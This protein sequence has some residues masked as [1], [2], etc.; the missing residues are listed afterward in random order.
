M[1]PGDFCATLQKQDVHI[2]VIGLNSAFLQLQ[3]GDYKGKLVLHPSQLTELLGMHHKDWLTQHDVCFLLT[4]HPPEWLEKNARQE[5][6]GEI[7]L[8]G[9]FALHLCGHQHEAIIAEWLGGGGD[10]A[11]RLFLANSLFGRQEY[12]VWRHGESQKQ[13]DRRHGYCAGVLQFSGTSINMR[14]FP[15]IGVRKSDG[16]WG[17]ARDEKQYLEDDGGTKP[18][19]LPCG[20][21]QA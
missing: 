12:K 20:T 11:R 9:R 19:V 18:F 10:K 1:L 16:A 5:F 4:H 3:G 2:G 7:D 13:E 14:L 8:P 17:F 15:R 21:R 6:Y